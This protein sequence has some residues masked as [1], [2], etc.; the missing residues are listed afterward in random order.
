MILM[1]SGA[2]DKNYHAGSYAS[3]FMLCLRDSSGT[4]LYRIG[5]NSSGVMNSTPDASLQ[6]RLDAEADG[7][8]SSCTPITEIVNGTN[9]IFSLA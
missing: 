4:T 1:F 6:R 2:F 7:E 8:G 9:D 3:G 5:F